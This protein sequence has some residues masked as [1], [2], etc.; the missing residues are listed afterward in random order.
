MK[1]AFSYEDWAMG[2]MFGM[3][4]GDAMGAPIEFQPS[5]EPENNKQEKQQRWVEKL[6][7]E[8]LHL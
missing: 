7:L 8:D 2:M 6:L 4:I 1:Q 3:A 5:R